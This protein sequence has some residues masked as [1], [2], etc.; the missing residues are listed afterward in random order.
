MEM[1]NNR[2]VGI[3]AIVFYNNKVL[4]VKN[5]YGAAKGKYVIPGGGMEPYEMPGAT[6]ERE[7][8][9]E[10]SV[11][12]KTQEMIGIRFTTNAIWC[13]FRADYISGDPKP[14]NTEND[15]AIFMDINQAL[16]SDEVIQTSKILIKS[17]LNDRKGLFNKS[18]FVNPR[19]Q[20][21]EWQLYI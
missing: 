9:E 16:G 15:S 13:V 5:T 3:G 14:D 2:K 8:F 1:E 10:T 19:F 4:L 18:D 12:V 20:K 11:I 17:L 21:N 6:L 7:I